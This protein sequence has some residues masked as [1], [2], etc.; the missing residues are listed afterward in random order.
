MSKTLALFAALIAAVPAV[1]AGQSMPAP[2]L[3]PAS[4]GEPAVHLGAIWQTEERASLVPA[5]WRPAWP[6]LSLTEMP[7]GGRSLAR[8]AVQVQGGEERRVGRKGFIIG[9]GAGGG[10]HRSPARFFFEGS[11]SFA[12]LTDLKIG[13]APSDQ[14]LLHYSNRVAWTTDA[15]YDVVGVRRRK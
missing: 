13:Y 12:V 10:V 2:Q 5:V 6:A 8:V 7:E 9:I 14:L 4:T 11:T 3:D 1:A 15:S